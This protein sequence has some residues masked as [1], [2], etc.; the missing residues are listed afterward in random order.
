ML[1]VSLCQDSEVFNSILQLAPAFKDFL[2]DLFSQLHLVNIYNVLS[3][4]CGS[5]DL[6]RKTTWCCP[7]RWE[8]ARRSGRQD[9][10]GF[11]PNST[12]TRPEEGYIS[13]SIFPRSAEAQETGGWQHALERDACNY[14]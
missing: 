6:E 11:P 2:K 9:K 13:D 5:G 12:K 1:C 4:G 3:P 7:E 10:A 14:I 8:G